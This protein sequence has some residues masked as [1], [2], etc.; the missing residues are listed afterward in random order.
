MTGISE[1]TGLAMQLAAHAR[2]RT[3]GPL[4]LRSPPW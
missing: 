3:N 4:S 1:L 2:H